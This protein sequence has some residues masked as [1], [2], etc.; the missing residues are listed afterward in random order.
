MDEKNYQLYYYSSFLS[1][2]S[3]LISLI[4][5][6]CLYFF[7]NLFGFFLIVAL[8]YTIIS[9]GMLLGGIIQCKRHGKSIKAHF[10]F[11]ID[12]LEKSKSIKFWVFA[13]F[14][15]ILIGLPI[16]IGVSITRLMGDLVGIYAG[17]MGILGI[18]IA[19]FII[20]I[21]GNFTIVFPVPYSAALVIIGI[22]YPL[23]LWDVLFVGVMAGLGAALGELSAWGLGRSQAETIEDS[24]SGKQFL[25]LKSQIDKGYGGFLVFVY[26]ATPLPDDVL[27]IALGATKYNPVKLVIWCFFGKVVLCLIT[28]GLA[29]PLRPILGGESSNP[30]ME[31]AW[32]VIGLLI[33]LLIVYVDW[34]KIFKRN[35]KELDIK[36][37]AE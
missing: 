4:L 24:E 26:A 16:L 7:A 31:T 30:F 35:R 9:V 11:D 19:V 27:L 13:T 17:F 25:K 5:G 32:I 29:V 3:A 2:I 10:G 1:I 36:S 22:T 37:L 15:A 20:S 6:L 18:G 34:N 23:T 33:I 28:I 21:F 12:N 8:V 14:F